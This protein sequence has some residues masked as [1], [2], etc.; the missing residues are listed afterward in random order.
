MDPAR[1]RGLLAVLREAGVKRAKVPLWDGRKAAAD[2]PSAESLVLDVE[3]EPEVDE[4]ETPVAN[5]PGGAALI[6]TRT[7]QPVDLDEGAPDLARDPGDAIA[8]AN[9]PP[10]T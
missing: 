9:F 4:P 1:L 6:D 10:K 5:A 8:R 2:G 3:F 7:G